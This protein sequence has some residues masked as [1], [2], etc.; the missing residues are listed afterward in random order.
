M[1]ITKLISPIVMIKS[2]L[3]AIL[4]RLSA[5]SKKRFVTIK[6]PT[7]AIIGNP[8]VVIEVTAI[9][10]RGSSKGTVRPEWDAEGI[11]V[12]DVVLVANVIRKDRVIYK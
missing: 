1:V 3:A 7:K 10:G 12:L 5:I 9:E 4:K 8:T 2:L 6:K 11:N